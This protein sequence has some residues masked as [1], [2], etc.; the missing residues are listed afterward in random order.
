VEEYKQRSD[1]T[2]EKTREPIRKSNSRI[3]IKE[4]NQPE[5]HSEKQTAEY[6]SKERNQPSECHSKE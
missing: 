5:C 1:S 3:Q 6:R 2:G 4:R